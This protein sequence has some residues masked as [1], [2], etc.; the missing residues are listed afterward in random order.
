MDD[1]LARI[2]EAHG[3]LEN[4]ANTAGL[5][6]KLSLGGPFWE[7]RGW[8]DLYAGQTVTLETHRQ[9]ITFAPFTAPDRASTLDVD[10]ERVS[11]ETSD[12]RVV[13]ERVAPRASFPSNF[14]D[15]KTTWDREAK[16]SRGQ[17]LGL[18]R[19]RSPSAQPE[20]APVGRR[21][22]ADRR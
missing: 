13:E 9:H 1:L 17:L 5:T 10:P 12:G 18:I 8:P 20:P 14:D 16:P 19:P 2:L 22:R 6:A 21:R 3:G 7:L 15:F 4:W 11:I